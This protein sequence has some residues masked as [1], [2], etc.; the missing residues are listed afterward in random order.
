VSRISGVLGLLV[1][2]A[3]AVMP[4]GVEAAAA[5]T[6]QPACEVS[7]HAEVEASGGRFTAD[8]VV[9][10]T[11]SATIN[12]WTLRF[13][14][15][16]GVEIVEFPDGVLI[17]G[18]REAALGNGPHN[19][20]VEPQGLIEVQFKATGEPAGTPSTFSVNGIACAIS[21]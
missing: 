10:N 7:Y 20:T 14:L 18:T 6:N 17:S 9:R 8:L 4:V 1:G 5:G 2:T 11:G 12:G 19:G 16:V 13:P 15:A 21:A 3:C